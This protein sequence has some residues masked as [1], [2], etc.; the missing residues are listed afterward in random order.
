MRPRVETLRRGVPE[1]P[2]GGEFAKGMPEVL[3]AG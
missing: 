1:Q 3:E 2:R